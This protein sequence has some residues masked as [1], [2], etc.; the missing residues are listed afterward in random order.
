MNIRYLIVFCLLTAITTPDSV[1]QDIPLFTQKLTNSFIYNPSVA[2]NSLGSASLSHRK[3]WNG[4]LGSPTTN[5]FS[6]HTPFAK[7]RF[8]TGLNIYQEQVGIYQSLSAM[9]AFAYHIKIT[10]DK[11]LSFGV[12]GE[13]GNLKIDQTQVDVVDISDELIIANGSTNNIDFSFG[14]TLALKYMNIGIAANRL[15]SSIR[16]ISDNATNFPGFYSTYV[17]GQIPLRQDRDLL[18]PI[19]TYRSYV[20]GESQLD[21]GL[22]YTLNDMF[23]LGGAYR[24]GNII[25]A[26]LGLRLKGRYMIGY[27]R[28]I[29]AGTYGPNVGS[30]NEFILRVDF[31]SQ[32]YYSNF[33]NAH[34]IN[35]QAL[36]VRRKTLSIYQHGSSS[37]HKKK[38]YKK[39]VNRNYHKS[40]NYRMN[41]SNKLQ[42]VKMKK[43]R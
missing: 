35:T 21:A 2:G 38:K 31:K 30:S 37:S 43:R 10:D 32:K 25:N 23:I 6:I 9:A 20:S 29:Y 19:V 34:A 17:Q 18:E 36:A 11:T 39:I 42:T 4:V 27:S 1:A 14:M 5:F 8:G 3:N 7:D 26:S 40:P 13:Y 16:N 33:K 15:N 24:T 12:S 41:S 28:D 22:F